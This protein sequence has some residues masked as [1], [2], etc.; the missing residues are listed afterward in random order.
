ML[1]FDA[2][3]EAGHETAGLTKAGFPI[4]AVGEVLGF[5][6]AMCVADDPPEHRKT[7]PCDQQHGAKDAE[8]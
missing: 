1:R 2:E 6:V 3:H 5:K 7:C 4:G 8:R